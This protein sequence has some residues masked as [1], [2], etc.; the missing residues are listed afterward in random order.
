[1]NCKVDKPY[2]EIKVE[3]ENLYYADILLNDYTGIVSET[4]AV[5]L[6]SYEHIYKFKENIEFSEV[7]EQ[8]SIVEM[9]H[10]E[11]LGKLITLLG[12]NPIF[13]VKENYNNYLTYWSSSF[14]DYENNIID[15][16]K[17]NIKGEE[18]AIKNYKCHASIINDKYIKG[19]LYRI[20]EDEEKHIECFKI[21]LQKYCY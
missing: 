20:I 4:S 1:V 12:G 13:K 8:I 6:Y 19:I 9:H 7:M 11:I 21:L 17:T 3:G 15:M 2:P 10:L 5:F 18:Q 14:I 16:L